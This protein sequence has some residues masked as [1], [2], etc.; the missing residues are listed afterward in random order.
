[1]HC[2][3]HKEETAELLR[4]SPLAVERAVG[5]VTAA[6]KAAT[7][8]KEPVGNSV[9]VAKT[10]RME[11]GCEVEEIDANTTE[12]EAEVMSMGKLVADVDADAEPEAELEAKPGAEPEAEAES[13]AQ[14]EPEA[15]VEMESARGAANNNDRALVGLAAIDEEEDVDEGDD[16]VGELLP[17]RGLRKKRRKESFKLGDTMATLVT[18][19]EGG[20]VVDPENVFDETPVSKILTVV[21]S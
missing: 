10:P 20:R 21:H 2:R 9:E 12:V 7:N 1:M 18:R 17:T 14:T 16:T 3:P 15:G 4:R 8:Q 6:E 19:R 11:G 5:K 13:K